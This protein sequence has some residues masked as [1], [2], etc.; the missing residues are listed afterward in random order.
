MHSSRKEVYIDSPRLSASRLAETGEFAARFGRNPGVLPNEFPE[1]FVHAQTVQ[2]AED[3]PPVDQPEC[4]IGH[5]TRR[6]RTLDA[7]VGFHDAR[8]CYRSTNPTGR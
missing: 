3:R 2:K 7:A 1:G 4:L 8:L 5:R 6:Q